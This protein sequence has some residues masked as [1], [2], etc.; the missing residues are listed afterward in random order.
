MARYTT[1]GLWIGQYILVALMIWYRMVG[2]SA[3]AFQYNKRFG[4]LFLMGLILDVILVKT[5]I[6]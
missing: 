3:H 5:G 1:I 2:P 6:Y 4:A